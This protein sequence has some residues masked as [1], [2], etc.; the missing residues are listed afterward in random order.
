MAK[1]LGVRIDDLTISEL[2]QRS[3]HFLQSARAHTVFTP[4]AEML[5]AAARDPEFADILNTADLN[6]CDGSGPQFVG[7]IRNRIQG[8]LYI[9]QLLKLAEERQSGVYLLGTGDQDILAKAIQNMRKRYPEI[10]IVGSHPGPALDTKGRGESEA[11]LHDIIM[12]AP[13]IL[14][15]AFGHEK[16]ERWIAAHLK[17]LPSVRIAVGV[18]GVL[19]VWS[20]KLRPA[21]QFMQRLGIE[22]LYRLIQ[23]PS[24]IGRIIQA[25]IIFPLIWMHSLLKK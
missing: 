6:I 23:Q 12:S 25:V 7:R 13:E 15:V 8:G 19:D 22:W 18:G 14:I 11:A 10:R 5:I 9:S 17:E 4:N 21:P 20:G 3:S 24:R 2:M 1:V 16:Q